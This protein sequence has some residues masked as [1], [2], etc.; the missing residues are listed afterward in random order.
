M[1]KYEK[2]SQGGGRVQ[3]NSQVPVHFATNIMEK[4]C[5]EQ[6]PRRG[7]AHNILKEELHQQGQRHTGTSP[8]LCRATVRHPGHR[9]LL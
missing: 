2:Q 3:E 4:T 7:A 6:A 5:A 8:V 9:K 1:P